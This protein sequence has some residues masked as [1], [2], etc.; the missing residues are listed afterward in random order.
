[1]LTVTEIDNSDALGK[2]YNL[3]LSIT[4]IIASV[5]TSQGSHNE[6]IVKGGRD[7][8][9]EN[10]SLIVATLKRQAKIGGVSFDDAGINIEELVELFVLL[11]Q[12]TNYLAVSMTGNLRDAN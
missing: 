3:L 8:L 5:V 12:S 6:A 1:M 7:F 11:I 10:R 2:Y 4:R 9:A